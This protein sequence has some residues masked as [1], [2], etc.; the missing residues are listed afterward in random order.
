[1]TLGRGGALVDAVFEVVRNLPD[2]GVGSKVKRATWRGDDC[3]WTVTQ[4]KPAEVRELHARCSACYG[5][6]MDLTP[7]GLSRRMGDMARRGGS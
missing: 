3:Y 4:V 7:C 5:P 6:R 2:Y 1:M